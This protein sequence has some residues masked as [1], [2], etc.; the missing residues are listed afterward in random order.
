M[1]IFG[2]L[3][4]LTSFSTTTPSEKSDCLGDAGKCS[5]SET[6]LYYVVCLNCDSFCCCLPFVYI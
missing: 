4:T 3:R 1:F 5:C 2:Q 6:A